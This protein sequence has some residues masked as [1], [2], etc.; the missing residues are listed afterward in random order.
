MAL[1]AAE[2]TRLANLQAAR[3]RILAGENVV[4]VQTAGRSLDYGPGDLDKLNAAIGDLE[5]RQTG[6]SR[7]PIRFRFGC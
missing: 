5:A 7:G 4:K 3:D 6:R 2:T 1:T